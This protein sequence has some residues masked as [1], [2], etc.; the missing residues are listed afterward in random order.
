MTQQKL[1]KLKVSKVLK[2]INSKTPTKNVQKENLDL[3]Q[4]SSFSSHTSNCHSQPRFSSKTEKMKEI[5]KDTYFICHIRC[6]LFT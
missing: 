2:A 6:K 5:L 4:A 3:P 1:K